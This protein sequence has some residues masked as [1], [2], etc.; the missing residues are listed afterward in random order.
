MLMK[1]DSLHKLMREQRMWLEGSECALSCDLPP[2]FCRWR[3]IGI[4]LAMASIPIDSAVLKLP[5]IHKAT[6]LCILLI[7]FIGYERGALL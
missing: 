4:R 2:I 3:L 7:I 5:T 1:G 6:L